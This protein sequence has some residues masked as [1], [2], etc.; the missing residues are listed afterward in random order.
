MSSMVKR[1]IDPKNPGGAFFKEKREFPAR[2]G[3]GKGFPIGQRTKDRAAGNRDLNKLPPEVTKVCEL[4]VVNVCIGNRMLQWCHP[5]KSR[6]IV[7]KKDWRTAARGCAAC[8]DYYERKSH[9]VMAGAI[10]AAIAK[11]KSIK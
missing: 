3:N 11:R 9:V 10:R 4:R 1:P 5:T 6:F 8:H 7:T 2:S